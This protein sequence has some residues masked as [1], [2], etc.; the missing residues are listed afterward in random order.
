MGFLKF[1]K[2]EKK[3]SLDELD[4][5]PAPPPLDDFEEDMSKPPELPDLEGEDISAPEAPSFSLPQDKEMDDIGKD[6]SLPD[7]SH[8]DT[9]LPSF[10]DIDVPEINEED[11]SAPKFPIFPKADETLPI[12][13]PIQSSPTIS[14]LPRIPKSAPLFPEPAQEP[15]E[16][17]NDEEEKPIFTSP[18][19][20]QKI[21]KRL[22]SQERRLLRERPSGKT[23]YVRVDNFKATLGNISIVRS[24]LRKSE[25]ALIKLESMKY[26]K[27]KS[28]DKI[29]Y[30]LDD[31]QKKIIFVDK[32][33]FKGE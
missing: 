21:E 11:L 10:P 2:R 8:E 30:L 1:L 16:I 32:T 17:I 29:R 12:S 6:Y 25:D 27:D 26:S 28:F 24:D 3:D 4:L 31:V 9:G 15:E 14:A 23:I 5:P 33:L 22:F 13:L 18:S 20:Y 19:S 7:L